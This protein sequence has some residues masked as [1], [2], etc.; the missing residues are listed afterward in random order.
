MLTREQAKAIE[1]ELANRGIVAKC[2]IGMRYWS[3][4]ATEVSS[5]IPFPHDSQLFVPLGS[6]G[7]ATRWYH[8]F[9]YSSSLS[10]LL[11]LHIWLFFE[12]VARIS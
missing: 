9:Y 6:R 2:Y 3:P 12:R 8:K 7:G 10:T 4:Y 5:P 11:H 1:T